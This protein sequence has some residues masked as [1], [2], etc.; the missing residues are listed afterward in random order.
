MFSAVCLLIA[1][2]AG[3][4]FSNIYE[5]Y[6]NL[7]TVD[8][9]QQR[10][11]AVQQHT[12]QIGIKRNRRSP[13]AQA[14]M[15]KAN[16]L[17]PV[18]EKHFVSI[19]ELLTDL[20]RL[21]PDK[22]KIDEI[23]FFETGEKYGISIQGS[24]GKTQAVFLFLDRMNRSEKFTHTLSQQKITNSKRLTFKLTAQWRYEASI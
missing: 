13:E 22:L 24:S 8:E 19:P 20:E 7:K 2:A 3:L 4:T 15:D 16:Q 9:Y 11:A 23:K 17:R 18:L 12:K 21:K 5:Y 1:L 14:A 10:L 6:A